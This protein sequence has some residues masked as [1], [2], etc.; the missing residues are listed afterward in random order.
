VAYL[1]RTQD[2]DGG[3]PG[4][5]HWEPHR[6]GLAALAGLTLLECGAPTDDGQVRRA[7][8]MVRE[9]VPAMHQTYH[10]ALALLFLDRLGQAEDEPLIRT[11]ALR[12]VA[13]QTASGGWTYVCPVLPPGMAEDLMA[14]L[15]ANQRHDLERGVFRSIRQPVA[16]APAAPGVAAP[17]TDLD[18]PALPGPRRRGPRASLAFRDRA[19]PALRDPGPADAP[20]PQSHSDNSNTQFATL[21]LWVAGRCGLPV[22]RSLALLARRFRHSQAEDGSWAYSYEVPG[23]PGRRPSMTGAGLLGLAVGLGLEPQAGKK[24]P[25]VARGLESLARAV[26]EPRGPD[27]PRDE[28]GDPVDHY[29]FWTLERV[30][31]LYNLPDLGGKDWYRW[32]AEVLVDSQDR[33]GS[34]SGGRYP[35]AVPVTDT[36]FALLFLRR[37]NLVRDLSRHLDFASPRVPQGR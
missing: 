23:E 36:C 14:A 5:A 18:T 13:G 24:E 26:G 37:A 29:F 6:V 31:V 7:A 12:L 1:R 35:G 22:E 34:W 25:A 10:L 11:L 17:G 30:A 3:W 9:A 19:V 15:E 20:L 28:P 27:R 4:F 32:G 16:A 33:D 2:P 8:R 21:A